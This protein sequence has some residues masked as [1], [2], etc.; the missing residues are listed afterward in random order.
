VFRLNPQRVKCQTEST[1]EKIRESIDQLHNSQC[2][3][4]EVIATWLI[5][6]YQKARCSICLT[7]LILD[8]NIE[9]LH[10]K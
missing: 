8:G 2:D 9:K 5:E 1:E 10:M 6:V 4:D 7:N 3:L